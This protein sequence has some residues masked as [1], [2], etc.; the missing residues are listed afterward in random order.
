MVFALGSPSPSVT[1][2]ERVRKQPSRKAKKTNPSFQNDQYTTFDLWCAK[3]THET[4]GPI[5]DSDNG[6]FETLLL[7]SRIFPNIY[8]AKH[9]EAVENMTKSMNPTSGSDLAHWNNFS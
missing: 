5:K 6:K 2:L 3:A 9:S 8:K 4:F 1:A 7:R